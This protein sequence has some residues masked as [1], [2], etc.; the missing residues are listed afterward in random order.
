MFILKFVYR[1]SRTGFIREGIIS[2]FVAN[3]ELD[4]KNPRFTFIVTAI[5]IAAAT[6][7]LPHPPNLTAVGA[8]TIF[9]GAMLSDKR[10]AFII[11]LA[12]MFLSDLII[13]N[14]IYDLG[15]FTVF[16]PYALWVYIPF[17]AMTLFSMF[18]IKRLALLPILGTSITASVLFFL[19]SNMGSWL[20]NPMYTKDLSGLVLAWEAGLPFFFNTLA[21]DLGFSALLFGGFALFQL[22]FPK[23]ARAKA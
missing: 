9:G 5:L 10:L 14:L 12:A 8:M 6:R 3:T 1:N 19:T 11:P 7:L 23:L 4:M 15:S 17:A 21:G 18:S 2:I 22:R 16:H 13:N 20:A